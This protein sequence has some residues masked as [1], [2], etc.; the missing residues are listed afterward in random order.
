MIKFSYI[1]LSFARAIWAK[2]FFIKKH[3]N[4]IFINNTDFI[5][6]VCV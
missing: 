3:N 4:E 2:D 6:T 5:Y 1:I